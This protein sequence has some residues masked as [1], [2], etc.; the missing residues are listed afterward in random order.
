MADWNFGQAFA[1]TA[2]AL[3]RQDIEEKEAPSRIAHTAALARLQNS[4]AAEAEMRL[5]ADRET[6]RLISQTGLGTGSPSEQGTKLAEILA[7]AGNPTAAS[8]A[9]TRVAQMKTQETRAAADAARQQREQATRTITMARRYAELLQSVQSQQDLDKV[10]MIMTQEAGEEIPPQMRTYDP[11]LVKTLITASMTAAQRAELALKQEDL[12]RK[13]QDSRSRRALN[14]ARIEA[15]R[16]LRDVRES[17]L[18]ADRKVGGKDVPSPRPKEIGAAEDVLKREGLWNPKDSESW[19]SA[20]YDLAAYAHGLQRQNPNLDYGQ[21]LQRAFV[22]EKARGAYALG[23]SDDKGGQRYTPR[24]QDV[25]TKTA[26]VEVRSKADVERLP[27]G[28]YFTI[29]GKT[30][31][32]LGNGKAE[33]LER[34]RSGKVTQPAD[35]DDEDE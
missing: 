21:A 6:A 35:A 4:Q 18:G 7:R 5:N 32:N 23:R 31:K 26:P 19:R 33:L 14:D 8:Q 29:G 13:E 25:G 3:Q 16:A 15:T 24:G 27:A 30:Y 34:V 12:A 11:R 17:K 1:Q 28:A 2:G 10:N 9:L 22:E 20:A